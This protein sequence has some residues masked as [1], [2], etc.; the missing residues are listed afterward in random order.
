MNI[1]MPV[2]ST[3]TGAE[4]YTDHL[5]EGLSRRGHQVTV[6]KVPHRFQYAPWFSGLRPPKGAQVT[7]ANSWSAAAFA[8]GPPLVTVVHHV[9]HD[10]EFRSFKSTAQAVFHATFVKTMERAAL[11]KSSSV[12][13]VSH[14]TAAAIR[15][16]LADIPVT[17]IRNGVD[18]TYFSPDPEQAAPPGR[19]LR[20]LYVGKRSRRKGFDLVSDLLR[21]H[22]DTVE[23]T[24]VGTGAEPGMELDG[25]AE[26][27]R[28]TLP[29]LRTA[30]R[31]ADFLLFPSRLEGFG[32]VAAEAMACGCPVLCIDG[33]A[34][35]EVIS[36]PEGG[37][38]VSIN[39]LPDL[40]PRAL[41]LREDRTRYEA[42]RRSARDRTVRE[43]CHTRWLDEMETAL[44][45]AAGVEA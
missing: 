35:A 42:L 30:Y 34:V 19:R 15:A 12:I 2:I 14:T 24:V 7:L 13:A 3:G 32:L 6:D 8:K 26:L 17:V 27:G 31:A 38:A 20:L 16:H 23:L 1:W 41:A 29:E 36:A 25:V 44:A 10:P 33:G 11:Q 37:I 22:A 5:A 45:G 43:F 28:L 21:Q 18:T 39:D 40:L 9:V 4:V